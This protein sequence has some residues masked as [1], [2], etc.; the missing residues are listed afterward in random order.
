MTTYPNREHEAADRAARRRTLNTL[1]A[2]VSEA[3]LIRQRVDNGRPVDGDN[4]QMLSSLVRGL[5][6]YL[7]ELGTLRDVR[8]WDAADKRETNNAS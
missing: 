4:T 8:E 7:A 1:E 6:G 3:A 5:T 2:I